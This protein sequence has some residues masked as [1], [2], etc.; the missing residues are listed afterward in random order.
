[1][2]MRLFIGIELPEPLRHAAAAAA[3][4]LR[5]AVEAGAPAAAIRWVA[6]ASLHITVWFLGRIDDEPAER[7]F[8]ILRPSL[9]T[10]GFRMTVAD[11]GAFPSSGAPRALWLGVAAGGD[12]LG[13]IHRELAERL[14]PL[15][16]EPERRP[17]SPHLT[18][19][20]LKDVARADAAAL[21]RA[22]QDLGIAPAA[23]DIGRV[24]LFRSE[25]LA[26]GSRYTPVLRV[27]LS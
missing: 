12:A 26:G 25:P 15:G 11:A 4:Q 19:A 2:S 3:G 7:L 24:T 14:H 6:P 27:P 8:E 23:A 20:R 13:A 22:L 9:E 18:V 5:R 10:P 16:F 21:R 1:M 17:Y